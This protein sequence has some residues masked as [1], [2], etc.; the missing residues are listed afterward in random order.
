MV[1]VEG[2]SIGAGIIAHLSQEHLQ[3]TA[4]HLYPN[5]FSPALGSD[6][7]SKPRVPALGP[8]RGGRAVNGA[9]NGAVN[10][11]VNEGYGP[12]DDDTLT[13]GM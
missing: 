8:T 6:E 4:P 13:T 7:E 12:P 5:Y 1:N 10:G 11:A 2:D 3:E 9:M